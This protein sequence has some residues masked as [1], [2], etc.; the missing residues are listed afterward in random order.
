MPVDIVLKIYPEAYDATY[1]A[2][3]VD[4]T[5]VLIELYRWYGKTSNTDTGK[6]K[7][8]IEK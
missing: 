5:R 7:L 3:Q 6:S 2:L 4:I 1:N 8:G